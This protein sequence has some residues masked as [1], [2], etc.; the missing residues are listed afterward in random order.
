MN[1]LDLIASYTK[2]SKIVC[3]IGC[4]HAYALIDAINKYGVEKGIPADINEGPL[5]N[6]IKTINWFYIWRITSFTFRH[7]N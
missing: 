2:G 5:N 7:T 3:D 4:D 1:R 6:A